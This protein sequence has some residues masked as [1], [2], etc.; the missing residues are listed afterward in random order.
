MQISAAPGCSTFAPLEAS[1]IAS[2]Y[3]ISGHIRVPD[4]N[5]GSLDSTPSTSVQISHTIA[6]NAAATAAPVTSLPPRPR[7]VISYVSVIPWN[8][9]MITTRPAPSS[10]RIRFVSIE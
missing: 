1:S 4:T 10:P 8:P 2:S 5:R 3:E 6:P 9:V 7:V